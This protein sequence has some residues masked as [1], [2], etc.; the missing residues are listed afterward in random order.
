MSAEHSPNFLTPGQYCPPANMFYSQI[1]C[2]LDKNKV[3]EFIG[4]NGYLFKRITRYS[5][6]KYLWYD[7]SR[8][9]IEIWGPTD[10]TILSAFKQ[11]T[12]HMQK[13]KIFKC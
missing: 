2:T 4:K 5:G 13:F 12:K 11:V 8:N 7:N 3:K 1:V 9:M 10:E 6:V